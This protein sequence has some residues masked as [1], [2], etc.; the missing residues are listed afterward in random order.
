VTLQVVD[1][2]RAF[3]HPRSFAQK[4]DD[5]LIRKMMQEQRAGDEIDGPVHEGKAKGVATDA[6]AVSV[7]DVEEIAVEGD[8]ATAGITAGDYPGGVASGGTNIQQRKV[9]LRRSHSAQRLQE[10]PMSAESAVDSDKIPEARQR[11]LFRC[12]VHEL[13]PDHPMAERSHPTIIGVRA[14]CDS[15]VRMIS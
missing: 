13:G 7:A 4:V 2:N 5:L 8:N 14:N 12:V 1:E 11:I 15:R 10:Y 6:L 9:V 3:R